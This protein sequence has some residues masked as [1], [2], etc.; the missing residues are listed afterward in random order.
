MN[1]TWTEER[2]V[3]LCPSTHRMPS[4]HIHHRHHGCFWAAKGGV[5]QKKDGNEKI[6]IETKDHETGLMF[7]TWLMICSLTNS[8]WSGVWY[9]WCDSARNCGI[10]N[11]R[12]ASIGCALTCITVQPTTVFD[13][14]KSRIQVRILLSPNLTV[15]ITFYLVLN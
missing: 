3:I 10:E 5:D 7:I 14:I 2:T 4:G 1:G 15:T 6:K 11:V 13:N 9:S 12:L 8:W